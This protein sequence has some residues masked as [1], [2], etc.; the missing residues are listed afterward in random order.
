MYSV[1]SVI[2]ALKSNET[3][4][5]E[6]A[7]DIGCP[8]PKEDCPKNP[9]NCEKG[10]NQNCKQPIT[11]YTH[12]QKLVILIFRYKISENNR[13]G[14]IRKDD[15]SLGRLIKHNYINIRQLEPALKTG[16]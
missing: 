15:S 3:L 2:N 5:L 8:S 11:I 7:E 9:D 10:N 13:D 12:Y 16:D 4:T 6:D 14:F 1:A